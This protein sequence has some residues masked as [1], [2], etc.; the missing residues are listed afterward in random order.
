MAR[1]YTPFI[2]KPV[3]AGTKTAKPKKAAPKTK[4]NSY[5]VKVPEGVTV[6]IEASG[7][8]KVKGS[9]GELSRKFSG[10]S[11]TIA[12]KD[13]QVIFS[14]PSKRKRDKAVIGAAHAHLKNLIHGVTDGVVY[15]MKIVYSHFPMNV[16][17]QGNTLVIDNFLG[18]KYPRKAP[19]LKNVKVEIK[20]QDVTLNGIDKELVSQTAA[21]IEQITKIKGRD[22]RVFQDGIYITEKDGRKIT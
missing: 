6:T 2:R 9:K 3:K 8:V 22:L 16:K 7:L 21:N 15:K 1:P 18:E 13:D 14:T 12:K 11:M 20:G 5:E 10:A 19:V 4:G 17:L